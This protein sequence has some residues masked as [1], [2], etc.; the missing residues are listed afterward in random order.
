MFAHWRAEGDL[1][2]SADVEEVA[3]D[4]KLVLIGPAGAGKT[5]VL[6]AAEALID[7]F[8][9]PESVRKCAISNAAARLLRGDTLHALCKLSF[10]DLQQK[11]GRL[12]SKVLKKHRQRWRSAAAMFFDEM[13]MVSPDQ[14][15]QADIRTRQAK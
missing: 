9:G 14:L 1:L 10:S 6:K 15:L 2:D 8:V 7:H 3:C 5:T 13:S 11:A 4:D 12:T